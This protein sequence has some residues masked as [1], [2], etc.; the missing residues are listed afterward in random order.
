MKELLKSLTNNEKIIIYPKLILN[1]IT[2]V[3]IASRVS[4]I[5]QHNLKGIFHLVVDDTINYKDLYNELIMGLGFN[6]VDMEENF[7][8]E[9][10]FAI[11]SKRDNE[12]PE[13]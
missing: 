6:N 8:E 2:D 1:T 9:G 11:L 12:F 3:V 13:Q 4:Y 5:I 7:E 10:Y